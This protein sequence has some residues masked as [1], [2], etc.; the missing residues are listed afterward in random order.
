MDLGL[1]DWLF[2]IG[3]IFVVAVLVHGYWRMRRSSN[4]VRVSLDEEFEPAAGETLE[5]DELSLLKAEL[6]TGGAR[7]VDAD[8]ERPQQ[9]SLNLEEDVPVLME[10]VSLLGTPVEQEDEP[11]EDRTSEPAGSDASQIDGQ[12]PDSSRPQTI[13]VVHVLSDGD[14]FNGQQLLE[15]LVA[16]DLKYGDMNIFHRHQEGS[17]KVL[18]S[19]VNG[20]EP[21]TFD[22]NTMQTLT[23]PAVSMFMKLQALDEPIDAYELMLDTARRLAD[24]MG[25]ALQDESRSALTNQTIEHWRQTI[26]EQSLKNR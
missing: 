3:P 2:I 19:L 22:L 9:G 7:V 17:D 10:P 14:G 4:R 24:E 8:S 15:S 11:Q 1:R 5:I 25:G 16:C 26:R 18:F 21:G 6:P 12:E 20:V 23:T 13:V